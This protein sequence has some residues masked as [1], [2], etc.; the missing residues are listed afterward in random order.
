MIDAALHE[1][2]RRRVAHSLPPGALPRE[3][4]LGG[5]GLGLDS[6][7]IAE[8]LLDCEQR[9]GVPMIQLLDG[10]PLTLGRLIERLEQAAQE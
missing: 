8:V 4:T 1:I 6:I 9:F 2:V 7:A 3:Q 5:D 10:E